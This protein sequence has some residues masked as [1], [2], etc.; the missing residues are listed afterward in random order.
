MLLH[1]SS[2]VLAEVWYTA[3]LFSRT[4]R[5]KYLSW[6]MW[7]LVLWRV[8]GLAGTLFCFN[9]LAS[10]RRFLANNRLRHYSFL[11]FLWYSFI[12]CCMVYSLPCTFQYNLADS[13]SFL[14]YLLVPFRI[15]SVMSKVTLSIFCVTCSLYNICL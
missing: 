7:F 4:R 6:K 15:F 14:L 9:R 13:F 8:W 12:L 11:S 5:K 1:S 2:I 3:E 10:L